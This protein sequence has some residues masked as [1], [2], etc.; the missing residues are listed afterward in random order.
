MNNSMNPMIYVNVSDWKTFE[1]WCGAKVIQSTEEIKIN[2]DLMEIKTVVTST[3]KKVWELDNHPPVM[4]LS[5]IR[6]PEVFSVGKPYPSHAVIVVKD[7]RTAEDVETFMNKMFRGDR[8][9]FPANK[10]WRAQT[11]HSR[12]DVSFDKD[13]PFFHYLNGGILNSLSVRFLIVVDLAVEGMNNKYVNVMGIAKTSRSKRELLQRIGR[14]IRAV[15]H[16]DKDGNKFAPPINHDRI[17]IITHQEYENQDV[18]NASLHFLDNMRGEIEQV[19]SI[20]E[21]AAGGS[22]IETRLDI[23]YKTGLTGNEMDIITSTIGYAVATGKRFSSKPLEKQLGG[24]REGKREHVRNFARRIYDLNKGQIDIARKAMF[25]ETL[26]ASVGDIALDVVI[27]IPNLGVEDA[28]T[29]AIDYGLEYLNDLRDVG[30]EVWL[31]AVNQVRKALDYKRFQSQHFDTTQHAIAVVEDIAVTAMQVI[32]IPKVQKDV[33]YE[34]AVT[35]AITRLADIGATITD[36]EADGRLDV[37]AV[38]Q[39]LRNADW[40]GQV[41]RWIR[42]EMFRNGYLPNLEPI[43]GKR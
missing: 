28:K 37:P 18:A 15:I 3:V 36:I 5:P 39:V 8:K 7:I 11:A 41:I 35:A 38:V 6:K 31:K 9:L 24:K 20:E 16:K 32:Q 12:H 17:H 30:E 23:D 14:L 19:I 33:V 10:G 34:L 21:Y 1:G 27:D 22:S 40:K 4:E 29:F 26:P 42:W 43:F 2:K 13:H 25:K